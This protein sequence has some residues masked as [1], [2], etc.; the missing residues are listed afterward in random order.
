MRARH[1]GPGKC[2]EIQPC[3]TSDMW[4]NI[5]PF[6]SQSSRKRADAIND[7]GSDDDL[8]S[9]EE[10]SRTALRPKVSTEALKTES[11]LQRLDQ[12]ALNVAGLQVDRTQSG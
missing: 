2:H 11:T 8:P 5:C 3:P 9:L 12:R 4:I 1:T 10:L 7:D 6:K